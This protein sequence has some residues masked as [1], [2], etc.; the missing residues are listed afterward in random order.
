MWPARFTSNST[1]FYH[2]IG[3]SGRFRRDLIKPRRH[4]LNGV[5]ALRIGGRVAVRAGV[6]VDQ[7]MFAP[8][9]TEPVGSV[10]LPVMEDD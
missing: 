7:V 1:L 10:T 8:G 5:A 3:E 6:Q 4:L 2:Q 9:M